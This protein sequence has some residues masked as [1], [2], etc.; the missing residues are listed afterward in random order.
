M[1]SD[2]PGT[3]LVHSPLP[4]LVAEERHR[5][6]QATEAL[7]LTFN[8]DFGF[9][10]TAVLGTCRYAGARVTL[11]GD[12]TVSA[13]DPRAV[14]NAGI[15]YVPGLAAIPGAFHPK[16]VVLAGP[17]RGVVAVG[18]GNVSVGGWQHN[19][20][21]WTL[22]EITAGGSIP[23]WAVDLSAWLDDLPGRVPMTPRAAIG[24]QRTGRQLADLAAAC[25]IE[26][27][28]ARLVHTSNAS[29]LS[30]LPTGPVEDLLLYAPFHDPH[31]AAIEALIAHFTP[32]RIRLSVQPDKTVLQSDALHALV[33]RHGI[34]LVADTETDRYR[35]GKLIEWT[36]EGQRW[37]LTG[38]ANLSAA[39]LLKPLPERGNCEIGLIAPIGESLFPE[40]PE[41][42]ALN[43][44]T[45]QIT[46][47]ATGDGQRG[48]TL[49]GASVEDTGLRLTLAHPARADLDIE[50]SP[51]AEDPDHWFIVGGV[52]SGAESI[53]LDVVLAGGSRIRLVTTTGDGQRV[54]GNTVFV[55]HPRYQQRVSVV[56]ANAPPFAPTITSLFEDPSLAGEY[57]RLMVDL[58]ASVAATHLPAI[59]AGP[60]VSD[61][62]GKRTHV[63]WHDTD[64]EG[65]AAYLDRE[66]HRVGPDLMRLV[67]PGLLLPS[68]DT[69]NRARLWDDLL[70]DDNEA[71]LVEDTAESVDDA[72]DTPT[73]DAIP[74]HVIGTVPQVPTADAARFRSAWK[75]LGAATTHLPMLH[76]VTALRILLLSTATGGWDLSNDDCFTT[77]ATATASLADGLMPPE[78][79]P[80]AGSI[81]A[82]ALTLMQDQTPFRGTN[83]RTLR[84]QTVAG[85][86]AHLLP[87]MDPAL[88][89]AYTR[90]LRDT[91]G[92]WLDPDTVT[93]TAERIVDHNPLHDAAHLIEELGWD[94][95]LHGPHLLHV[96][97]SFGNPTLAAFQALGFAEKAPLAGIWATSTKGKWTLVLWKT[98]DLIR[99][100]PGRTDNWWRHYRLGGLVGPS[101][102]A[103]QM[104]EDPEAIR[105]YEI[106]RPALIEPVPEG[107]TLLS[108]LGLEHVEPP[109]DCP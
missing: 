99:I 23:A 60:D 56:A 57:A 44:Q 59:S 89:E 91:D 26:D 19:S 31:E 13:P 42:D 92:V 35:H 27:D 37:A 24:V 20:E 15:T 53:D 8:L 54:P 72:I 70:V 50:A 108:E 66:T 86:V 55:V 77:L 1:S 58:S 106:K 7:F 73:S 87:A 40:G 102:L 109:R 6:G 107:L 30:Q 21:I 10:E 101:A 76:R 85:T 105:D 48:P 96:Q 22:V 100:E 33:A 39:A 18:S 64:E 47:A 98:P 94:A 46:P 82:V 78:V 2:S 104:R 49:L 93:V 16:V 3:V 4:F 43:V 83:A 97:G 62:E 11:V 67:F 79:E 88:I 38:S 69:V 12:A 32:A 63:S 103:A 17:Q 5:D 51:H 36:R 52:P 75:R 74:G 61:G 80:P 9:F 81:A 65:W 25:A 41:I 28:G 90:G 84:W 71:G 14:R 34:T 45:V 29:I 95:H 68:L